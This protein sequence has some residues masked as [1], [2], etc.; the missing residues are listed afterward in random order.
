MCDPHTAVGIDAAMQHGIDG[1]IPTI[2]LACAHPAK[3]P[4]T[5]EQALGIHPDAPDILN[6]LADAQ[7]FYDVLPA[8]TSQIKAFI[9]AK[10]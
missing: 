10:N 1:D 7:E 8:D 4:E 6:H 5:V 9:N 2:A 3:F